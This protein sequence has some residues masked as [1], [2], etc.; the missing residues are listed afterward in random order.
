[1]ILKLKISIS[2]K[3]DISQKKTRKEIEYNENNNFKKNSIE[4]IHLFISI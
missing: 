4:I 1:M 2:L 3:K